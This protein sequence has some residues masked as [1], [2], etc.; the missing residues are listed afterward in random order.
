MKKF[1]KITVL[2][3]IFCLCFSTAV[4]GDVSGVGTDEENQAKVFRCGHL[5]FAPGDEFKLVT[6][7][8]V[9]WRSGEYSGT[10]TVEKIPSK[11]PHFDTPKE[12]PLVVL[13]LE[14]NNISYKDDYDWTKTIFQG[15]YSL[16]QY[17]KDMSFNQFAFVPAKETSAYNV[18]GNH[19]KKDKAND[20]VVHITVDADHGCWDL[21]DDDE[22]AKWISCL[23]EG[24]NK[25]DDYV[26]FSTFDKNQDGE[27]TTDE[28]AL[29]VVVA[30]YEAA[31]DGDL[32]EGENYY[33][34]SHAWSIYG[35]WY[36]YF[37]EEYPYPEDFVPC[38]D[39]VYV[40]S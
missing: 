20:G 31:F 4:F 24:V 2:V 39:G 40:S 8:D 32:T 16:A 37:S 29:A 1:Y 23:V 27:I 30:G 25:A 14:F 19:N 33:L 13:V 35:G 15:E 34:W 22:D 9:A 11:F 36:W 5:P 18:G 26:D 38:P 6:L 17:Y 21:S 28:M 3:L 12:I 7:D 10:S